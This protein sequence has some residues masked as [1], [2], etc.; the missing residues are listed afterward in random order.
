MTEVTRTK[1]TLVSEGPVETT[2]T[3]KTTTYSSSG[4]Y[5]GD[6][7][8]SLYKSSMSPRTTVITRSAYGS[9]PR[10][11]SGYNM[12]RSVSYGY[13]YGAAPAGAYS[14]VVGVGVNQVKGNRA[15][16]KKD[17]QDLNERLAGY[18]EK[19][20][21][22]EAQN[23]KLAS[24]L[25]Q[26]KTK[27][28]KATADIK[29]MY[30]KE[31]DE[32]RKLLDNSEKE[33]AALQI[34]VSTLEQSIEELRQK[35]AEAL[36]LHESDKETIDRQ[37]Q[38]LSDYEAELGLLRRRV[39]SLEDDKARDKKEIK[40]LTDA[41]NKARIDLDNETLNH[42]DAENR[43]QTLEEELE[44]LKAIHEQECKELACLAYRDPTQ[45][46]REFWKNEMAQCLREI[47]EAYDE[48]VNSIRGEMETF[49]NLKVQEFRT[50]SARTGMEAEHAKEESKRLRTQL[51]DLRQ[52]LADFEVRNAQLEKEL[53]LLRR[54]YEEKQREWEIEGNE[55]KS[56][57]VKLRAEM[58]GML[59][60]LQDIM[61]IKLSLELEIAAYRKL[62]EGE[63]NRG[64]LKTLVESFM[65][66]GGGG[67]GG[68]GYSSSSGYS[69]SIGYGEG[70]D[71]DDMKVSQV[72]KGEMSAKTTY[73][74][75]AKGPVSISE[76]SPDGKYVA[77]ENTGKKDEPLDGWFIKRYLEDTKKEI[78]FTFPKGAVIS[79]R[80]GQKAIKVWARGSRPAG[81][82][83]FEMQ[84][85]NTFGVG[86][87]IKTTLHNVNGEE[88]ATHQQ[89]TL[90]TS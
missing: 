20:R 3:R 46:N 86:A 45:E 4:G 79:S 75:S 69:Q 58:E 7:L 54:E 47:Q 1:R 26:L 16:E 70:D 30:Q 64:G 41:L 21:F 6:D 36:Q 39:G 35:Y 62:L 60:E 52:K 89:R 8:S 38:Q 90:Y 33:K 34:K 5:E 63:E 72:V 24:E 51:N 65:V 28:G 82:D 25:E 10:G 18:I 2:T 23:R 80:P 37:N 42:I 14:S 19:V 88:K 29:A 40:R 53:E 17:M 55:L 31:L 13:N 15:Q 74:R 66:S 27:W 44:F 84:D 76:C 87:N 59:K 61:D 43:R 11:G 85:N 77:L 67:G 9:A 57:L 68:G 49:Y 12:E 50:G 56:E 71:D 48:K 22:L 83:D 78:K 81:S 32:A 73:Q